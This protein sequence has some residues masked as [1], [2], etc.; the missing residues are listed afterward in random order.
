MRNM[1]NK[2]NYNIRLRETLVVDFSY[3]LDILK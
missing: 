3:L 1:S 2:D